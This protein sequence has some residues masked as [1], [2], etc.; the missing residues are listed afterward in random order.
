M[1]LQENRFFGLGVK[2]TRNIAQYPLHRTY[3]PAKFAV[4]VSNRLGGD[5]FRRKYLTMA[6]NIVQYPLHNVRYASAEFEAALTSG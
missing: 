2:V 1:H 5:A 6:R 4:V 3:V